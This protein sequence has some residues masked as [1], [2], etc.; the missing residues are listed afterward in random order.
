MA[1]NL[2]VWNGAQ[3]PADRLP[4]GVD[5]KD[6]VPVDDWYAQQRVVAPKPV[7]KKAAKKKAKD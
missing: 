2:F 5:V 7:A 3:Y 6:C 1:D 4:E